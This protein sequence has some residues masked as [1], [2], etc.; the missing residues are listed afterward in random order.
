MGKVTLQK[1]VMAGIFN[2]L[3][4]IVGQKWESFP[5]SIEL[6]AADKVGMLI[7]IALS[8]EFISIHL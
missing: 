2:E 8:V 4:Q 5:N 7:L 6:P 1:P 3:L